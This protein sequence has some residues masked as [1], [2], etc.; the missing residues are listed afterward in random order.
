M[1]R[2]Q[3][4][5]YRGKIGN[6]KFGP[7]RDYVGHFNREKVFIP[8][9]NQETIADAFYKGLLPNGE[10]YKDLKKFNYSTMEEALARA[11]KEIR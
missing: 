6:T 8:F 10:L 11:W 9:C 5:R 1:A 4:S 7:N 2:C 3:L